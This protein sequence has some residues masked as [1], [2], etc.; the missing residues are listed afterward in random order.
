MKNI[1]QLMQDISRIWVDCDHAAF[2]KYYD[3]SIQAN[4]YG[5][6]VTYKDI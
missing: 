4:Y 2:E 1:E 3:K 5:K 6:H